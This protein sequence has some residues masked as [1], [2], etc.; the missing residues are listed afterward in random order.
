M[1]GASTNPDFN[2][3]THAATQVKMPLMLPLPSEAKITSFGA[4]AKVTEPA[5]HR[6]EARK[7][8][9]GQVSDHG[10]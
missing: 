7:G 2:V 6:Y 9:P 4:A 5:Q 1:N 8:T 10:P 3:V